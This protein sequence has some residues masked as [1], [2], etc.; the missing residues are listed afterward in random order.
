LQRSS[1]SNIDGCSCD[2]QAEEEEEQLRHPERKNQRC[3]VQCELETRLALEAS[4][5]Q[6][7]NK[8]IAFHIRRR[9]RKG[10]RQLWN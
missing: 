8:A 3:L 2:E 6:L 4:V 1:R 9:G 5:V 10:N 7:A